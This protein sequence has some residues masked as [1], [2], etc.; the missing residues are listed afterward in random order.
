M[1]TLTNEFQHEHRACCKVCGKPLST[2][3]MFELEI[4]ERTLNEMPR[5]QE[6]ERK[7]RQQ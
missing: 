3:S 2:H 1:P 4:C 5:R 7:L 6:L